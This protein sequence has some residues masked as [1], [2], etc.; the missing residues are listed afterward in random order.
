MCLL[1]TLFQV[2]PG[3]PLVV[4][5]N[6]DERMDRP[7]VPAAVLREDEP[8]I[9]GGRDLLAGGTWLAVSERGV[10]AGLTNQPAAGGRDPSKRSRGELPIASARHDDAAAAVDALVG[11]V[12][13][14]SYNPCWMLVGDRDR[15]FSVAIAPG[16]SK[17]EVEELEPGLHVLEN[18]SLRAGSA[19]AAF[20]RGLVEQ[21]LAAPPGPG[22]AATAQILRMVLA[23]HR[24]A[25][26]EPRIDP[27]GRLWPASL[28]AACV[29]ADGYG[30]RSSAIVT[31]PATGLPSILV[32]D[33]K[34]CE[35]P[36]RDVS[37]L[38][39][40]DPVNEPA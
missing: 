7:A 31:V 30:T 38:W 35:T 14:A 9:V 5:A 8:R 26:A 27:S 25:L 34:P 10:V 33:G 3:A 40:T 29:H 19:K 36:M 15:L 1:I 2:V 22:P 18:A 4:A 23:D 17:P 28:T 32:A 21:G 12:D 39:T 6:R 24:P 16:S 20:V 37:V 11:E 13:P